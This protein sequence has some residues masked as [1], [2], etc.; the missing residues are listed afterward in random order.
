MSYLSEN[1]QVIVS[2]TAS[3][4]T[5]YCNS[6]D[7]INGEKHRTSPTPTERLNSPSRTFSR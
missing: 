6:L 1:E 2:T 3:N 4:S 5:S 7:P